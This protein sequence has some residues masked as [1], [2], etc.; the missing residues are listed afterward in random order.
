MHAS[1]MAW[2]STQIK[3]F[4]LYNKKVLEMGS[5]NV[6][7]SVRELFTGD[8][9]GIDIR[10]GDGVDQVLDASSLPEEL[11]NSFDVVVSTEM[12]EHCEDWRAVINSMKD[13]ISNKGRILL[14]TR[15]PGFGRHEYPGDYWRFTPEHMA[16][17]FADMRTKIESDWEHPGVFVMAWKLDNENRVDLSKIE[18]ES[19]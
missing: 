16:E 12:L 18:V 2:M 14:T 1:A 15:G 11:S 5:F 6:N 7:G 3:Q 9:L 13:A 8:Y 10:E 4:G 19:I 17:I